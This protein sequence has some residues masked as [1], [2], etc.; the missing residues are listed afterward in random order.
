MDDTLQGRMIV[1]WTFSSTIDTLILKA[2]LFTKQHK[3]EVRL[4]TKISCTSSHMKIQ[5]IEVLC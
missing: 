3:E 1:P 2:T 4:L 5:G